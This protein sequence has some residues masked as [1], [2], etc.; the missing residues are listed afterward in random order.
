MPARP[1][2]S[3]ARASPRPIRASPRSAT[4]TRRTA[5]S[6]SPCST[7]TDEAARR[8]S[9]ASRTNCSISAPISPRRARISSRR[10]DAAHRPGAGR[11]ARA[12]DRPDERGSGAAAELH[13]ARRRGRRG[14]SSI[15]PAPWCGGPSASAVAVAARA[16][17]R[18]RSP[19]STGCR[20]IC[21]CSRVGWRVTRAAIFSGSRA[22]HAA[23][24][25]RSSFVLCAMPGGRRMMATQAR[26]E[27]G[28]EPRGALPSGARGSASTSPRR[29]PTPTPPSSRCRTPRRPNGISPTPPGSS[30]PSCCATMCPATALHDESWAYLFNS[31]YEGEGERHRA[32]RAA[33]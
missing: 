5:R 32:R 19:I 18:W 26:P 1:G 23:A 22:R 6:A 4:S 9:A 15:S 16:S 28:D 31:Y 14:R 17:T 2:W 30:R 20:T 7:S 25:M 33:A 24:D 13:P 21:S 8:C 10:N 12:R 3:T 11:P 29:S 27:P